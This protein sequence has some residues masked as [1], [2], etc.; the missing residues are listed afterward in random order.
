[1]CNVEHLEANTAVALGW[2]CPF[3]KKS[4]CIV[5]VQSSKAVSPTWGQDP[6]KG[7]QDTFEGL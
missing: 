5:G 1:M 6:H 2:E 4:C 7:S 3:L